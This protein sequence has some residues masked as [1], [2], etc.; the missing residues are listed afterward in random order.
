MTKV[1]DPVC[2]MTVDQEKAAAREV[3]AGRTWYFCSEQ[4]HRMF[5]AD[6]ARYGAKDAAEAA[7]RAK[8]GAGGTRGGGI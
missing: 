8:G 4:C 7:E 2:G 5:V 6:P 1:I 3:R